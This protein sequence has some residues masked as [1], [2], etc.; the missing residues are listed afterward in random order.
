ML[1]SSI[2][3]VF[4]EQYRDVRI[5]KLD[6]LLV[7]CQWPCISNHNVQPYP[8][9]VNRDVQR[10]HLI[11][12]L[13]RVKHVCTL[14]VHCQHNACEC[15]DIHQA[16]LSFVKCVVPQASIDKNDF[17]SITGNDELLDH[18]ITCPDTAIVVPH[19]R[20]TSILLR[21]LNAQLR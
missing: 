7:E 1:T 4:P 14:M 16:D 20:L 18:V 3:P 12:I 8:S 9:A 2:M 6:E 21:S 19:C 15:P 13:A 17:L 11:P 10:C 5:L